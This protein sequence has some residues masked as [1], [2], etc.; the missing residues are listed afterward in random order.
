MKDMIGQDLNP[1]DFFLMSGGNPRYGGLVIEIGIVLSLG[2][3]MMRT[4]VSRFDK[5][6]AKPTN[7]TSKKVLRIDLTENMKKTKLCLSF[8]NITR[9]YNG[10]Q[11]YF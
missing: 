8:K 2:N 4:L 9:N 7:K 11:S 5:V 6:K 1:G 3:K 10:K